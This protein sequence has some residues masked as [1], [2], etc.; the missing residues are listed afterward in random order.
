M[1]QSIQTQI[2][3][4]CGFWMAVDPK[5]AALVAKLVW[6]YFA[7]RSC[8]ALQP[9]RLRSEITSHS[10]RFQPVWGVILQYTKQ[11]GLGMIERCMFAV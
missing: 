2:C 1:L 5:D 6:K 8:P 7:Q 10:E 4:P 11:P 9:Y 3:Q